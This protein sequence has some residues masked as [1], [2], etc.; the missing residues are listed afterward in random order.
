MERKGSRGFTLVELLIVV[1]ILGIIA[2]IAIPQFT[3]S[4]EGAKESAVASDLTALQK[5]VE[6]Y[7]HQ[8]RGR[9]PGAF[10]AS[11]G[12]AVNN[13]AQ[14][15]EAFEKQLTLYTDVD[16]RTSNVRDETYRYGPYIKKGLPVNPF[17]GEAGVT[18]DIS[19]TDI[20]VAQ[21]NAGDGTGWKFYI[22]TG[23]VIANHVGHF[24]PKEIMMMHL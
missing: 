9:Y 18:C 3:S 4:S 13:K 1:L 6:I 12:T 21:G 15:E 24:E 23:R 19:E 10:K 17:N 7:Y 5:A 20:T 22:K 11:D 14:A 2:G 8:H 16:G